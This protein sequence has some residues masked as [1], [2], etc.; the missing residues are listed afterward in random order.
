MP[1]STKQRKHLAKLA[2][3]K[4]GEESEDSDSE[5]SDEGGGADAADVEAS[6]EASDKSSDE[7]DDLMV[8]DEEEMR[9][10]ISCLETMR[11]EDFLAVKAGT[12]NALPTAILNAPPKPRRPTVY[13]GESQRTHRRK[14]A[15]GRI[16]NEGA[17]RDRLGSIKSFFSPAEDAS[18]AGGEEEAD[19]EEEDVAAP[20]PMDVDEEAS[21][22]VVAAPLSSTA[23]PGAVDTSSSESESEDDVAGG[24]AGAHQRRRLWRPTNAE[25]GALIAK[26]GD[27][28]IE[29]AIGPNQAVA[30]A[31][32]KRHEW[33]NYDKLRYL[34]VLRFFMLLQTGTCT[35]VRASLAISQIIFGAGPYRASVIRMWAKCFRNTNQLP[36]SRQGK[37]Q[38]RRSLIEDED[39][40]KACVAYLRSLEPNQRTAQTFCTWFSDIYYVKLTGV[41]R[42]T[43]LAESTA[44]DWFENLGWKVHACGKGIYVDGH[45]RE[46]VVTYRSEFVKEMAQFQQRMETYSGPKMEIVSPP[47]LLPTGKRRIVLVVQDESIYRSNDGRKKVLMEGEQQ[48]IRPKGQGKGIM[49]SGFA[50]PC[51]GPMQLS[52]EQVAANPTVGNSEGSSNIFPSG[53][54]FQ[55]LEYG[56]NRDGY[57]TND[58]LVQQLEQRAIPIFNLL[59][60]EC[61]ALFAFDNSANHHSMKSDALVA[62]RLNLSDGGKSVPHMRAGYYTNAG[63]GERVVQT[64]QTAGVQKGLRT[65]LQERG[66]WNSSLDL[67]R[68]KV[69]LGQQP[70]FATQK[71][72]LTEIVETAGHSIIF[73]PKFHPEFNFIE[74]MWGRSKV[75]TRRNC[76]YS[77]AALKEVVLPSLSLA[78]MDLPTIRHYAQRC[79]RNMDAY[80]PKNGVSLTCAQAE[81]AVKL[82]RSH[83]CIP[84]DVLTLYPSL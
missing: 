57:W 46:D 44:R 16:W 43:R 26:L 59:H 29:D 70:D 12:E 21:E 1:P 69:L 77:F 79:E 82:Y 36:I 35:Q 47:E 42:S 23:I 18:D 62:S 55:S 41:H 75:Y 2:R 66:L 40:R 56:K 50:C 45:E 14:R 9:K 28:Q 5:L 39:V 67:A 60:P 81:K 78:E 54:A 65:I 84:S 32:D 15:V 48:P 31:V 7:E 20:A 3:S 80:R 71:D 73:F 61:E 33:T 72:W 74:R 76:T 49:I 51:H 63:S 17:V 68:S 37:H 19:D 25:L 6:D 22:S 83:R 8:G 52:A 58:D 13:K 24:A 53:H 34:S 4:K 38:K 10:K 30:K 27:L 11:L 64:M